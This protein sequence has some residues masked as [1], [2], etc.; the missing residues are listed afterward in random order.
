[1]NQKYKILLIL[2]SVSL[3]VS[4]ILSL[5]P[6]P[7]ICDPNKGCDVVQTSPYNF[8]FGIKNSYYGIFIFAFLIFLTLSEIKRPNKNKKLLIKTGVAIGSL[9]TIYFLYIQIFVLNAYCKYCLVV[10]FSMLLALIVVLI[11]KEK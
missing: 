3:A 9:V 6:L 1:M 11:S 7:I 5:T 2:F 4:I 10:D 8:T